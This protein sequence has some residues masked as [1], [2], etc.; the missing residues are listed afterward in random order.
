MGVRR[1]VITADGQH[2][3]DKNTD[4]DAE[5]LGRFTGG[6]NEAFH[7]AINPPTQILVQHAD[8]K[9][10]MFTPLPEGED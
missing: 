2:R 6:I 5:L 3:R 10:V 7:W 4:D 9:I 1:D 8:G